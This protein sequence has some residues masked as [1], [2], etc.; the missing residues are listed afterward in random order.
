MI[1]DQNHYILHEYSQYVSHMNISPPPPPPHTHTIG[2][3]PIGFH[4]VRP[5]VHHKSLYVQLLLLLTWLLVPYR[6]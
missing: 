2:G 1:L 6:R 5:S 4:Q 3:R